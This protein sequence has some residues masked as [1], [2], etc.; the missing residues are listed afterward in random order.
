[1]INVTRTSEDSLKS[2]PRK[3]RKEGDPTAILRNAID[4]HKY[5]IEKVTPNKDTEP[6]NAEMYYCQFKE[7]GNIKR[8]KYR[9]M[10][11]SR[12]WREY[13]QRKVMV[14]MMESHGYH[15]HSS[16]NTHEILTVDTEEQWK[17]INTLIKRE[18]TSMRRNFINQGS[19]EEGLQ[20]LID[21]YDDRVNGDIW[22]LD[23]EDIISRSHISNRDL[24]KDLFKVVSYAKNN[25]LSVDDAMT[26]LE[27]EDHQ[28][29]QDIKK[30]TTD[31][32]E[33]QKIEIYSNALECY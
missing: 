21:H 17:A 12:Y 7:N 27:L 24:L 1:M 2:S 5:V 14:M 8:K 25:G 6:K 22:D 31:S 9:G 26:A 28:V 18:S 3:V 30:H 4:D 11:S 16:N 23:G 29:Y 13:K 20:Y 33:E 15:E 10:K 19:T 32:S